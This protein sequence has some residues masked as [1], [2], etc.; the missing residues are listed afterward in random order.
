MAIVQAMKCS[1]A[2]GFALAEATIPDTAAAAYA[3]GLVVGRQLKAHRDVCDG[4][5]VDA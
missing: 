5:L 2:C 3:A 4:R 1:R